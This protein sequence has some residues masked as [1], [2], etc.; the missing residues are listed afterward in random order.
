MVLNIFF[1]SSINLLMILFFIYHA[2]IVNYSILFCYQNYHYL[3]VRSESQIY[4][5]TISALILFDIIEQKIVN[6][7]YVQ[8]GKH[9]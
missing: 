4:Y 8:R 3:K 7:T 1:T 9:D 2:N 6:E 5:K